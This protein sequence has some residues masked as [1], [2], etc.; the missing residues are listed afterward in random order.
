MAT[1]DKTRTGG[2]RPR[3]G[4]V[5][6]GFRISCISG[7]LPFRGSELELRHKSPACGA[8]LSRCLSREASS[9]GFSL[10]FE[11]HGRFFAAARRSSLFA[12]SSQNTPKSAE[13][14]STHSDERNPSQVI[15]NN[16]RRYELLDT[17][18]GSRGARNCERKINEGPP[19]H[20]PQ[21]WGT[22]KSKGNGTSRSLF[23]LLLR[24]T[25]KG[26]GNGGMTTKAERQWLVPSG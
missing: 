19:L 3:P 12:F 23:A 21:R 9:L 10:R 4:T 18:R 20:K 17:L 7:V 22:R 5:D 1:N 14:Y 16:Q 2:R 24:M 26:K 6:H 8:F 15:E 13:N 25:A 11:R